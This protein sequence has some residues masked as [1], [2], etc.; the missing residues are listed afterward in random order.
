MAEYA[1]IF[2]VEADGSLVSE[3]WT[4]ALETITGFSNN[5]LNAQGGW[6]SLI[7]PDD[8]HHV[9]GLA[10]SATSTGD[11]K[12]S[13]IRLMTKQGDV[14][15]VRTVSFAIWDENHERVVQIYGTGQDITQEKAIQAQQARFV[16]HA[17][18]E[19]SHPVSSILMRLYLL[20][21]QPERLSEHLDALQPVADHLRRMI[22]D[23]REYSSLE[24]GSI[25]LQRREISLQQLLH[26]VTSAQE[27]RLQSGN[28]RLVMKMPA[29][30]LDVYVDMD[31]LQQALTR[32]IHYAINLTPSGHEITLQMEAE[33]SDKP[34]YALITL[35]HKGKVIEP[36]QS[37]TV[38][39]PF[40]RASE[41]N[42]T[43]TGL[44]LTIAREIIKL[45]GGSIEFTSDDD[46]IDVFIIKLALIDR[47]RILSA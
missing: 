42:V 38:F 24:Q 5:E 14:R 19:F 7:H 22:E 9:L 17:M 12:T 1:F 27:D 8:R 13:E 39:H 34:T 20:R 21:K 37:S 3:W 23:M 41:G 10:H 4:K 45:H 16:T 25:S 31:R 40:Y 29:P 33:P 44:E 32:L 6:L 15:W 36:D 11:S 46:N 18:H 47:Q 30:S 43:H 28:L 2:R 26:S 35:R